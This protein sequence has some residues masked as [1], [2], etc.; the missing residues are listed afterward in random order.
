MI[1]SE[2]SALEAP[3]LE[4]RAGYC[5]MERS[6]AAHDELMASISAMNRIE[7]GGAAS[8]PGPLT[9][10]FTVAAWN[11]ERCLF[12]KP[13]ASHIARLKP[14]IVLLSE[15]DNGMAR[16]AQRHPTAEIS[17]QLGTAYAYGI[18]FIEIGLGSATER[19]FCKDDFNTKG[20]H[21]NALLSRALFSRAFMIRLWGKRLWLTNDPEQ[22][23]IGERCAV[24]AVIET[25]SG[26]LVAVSVH[27]ES[28]TTAAYRERQMV[29]LIDRLD[30][31]FPG[32][33]MIIGGDL[34]TGNH[35]G[36]DFDA[37]GLFTAAADRGFLRHGEPIEMMTT[38]PSLITR[39]PE[40]AMKLD[41]F[42]SRG[43]T[44]EDSRI[45]S[46][47]DDT[48]RPL[49]DHDMIACTVTGLA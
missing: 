15:M 25:E 40:R 46:S 6:I 45:V 32:L 10:P 37:E 16:T 11:L 49:S 24:G 22:P 2:T 13:S 14:S 8:I 44:I 7:T 36:G 35:T 31:A 19:E 1:E 17:S 27:L 33:P 41:W 28:A 38:R 26:P 21:G 20:F 48:G 5:G 43:L 23:R 3:S 47:L 4:A 42:L 34:N 30:A 9:F 39:W 18:E 29:D 12:P